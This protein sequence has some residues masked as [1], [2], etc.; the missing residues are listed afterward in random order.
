MG[1]FYLIKKNNT[2]GATPDGFV[3]VAHQLPAPQAVHVEPE[4]HEH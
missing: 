4:A 2:I 1:F 3:S